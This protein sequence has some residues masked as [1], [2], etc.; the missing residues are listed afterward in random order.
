MLGFQGNAGLINP[1]NIVT[2]VMVVFIIDEQ[3]YWRIV[4]YDE[5]LSF[6][7]GYYMV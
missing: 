4:G 2:M 3:H 6:F 5:A 7:F 1:V